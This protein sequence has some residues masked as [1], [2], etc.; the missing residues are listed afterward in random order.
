MMNNLPKYFQN[1]ANYSNHYNNYQI[2][3]NTNSMNINNHNSIKNQQNYIKPQSLKNTFTIDNR[4]SKFNKQ[5]YNLNLISLEADSERISY[6]LERK[7][8][9]TGGHFTITDE[10]KKSK[11]NVKKNS[12]IIVSFFYRI[13]YNILVYVCRRIYK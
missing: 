10:R 13:G 8:D 4:I 12:K 7:A 9:I 2:N 3:I 11:H 5:N 1:S 6:L